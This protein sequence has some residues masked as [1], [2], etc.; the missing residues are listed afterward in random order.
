MRFRRF[1]ITAN[2]NFTRTCNGPE[3]EIPLFKAAWRKETAGTEP[4]PL[5]DVYEVNDG[6]DPA[7]SEYARLRGTYGDDLVRAVYPTPDNLGMAMSQA[8]DRT[9]RWEDEEKARAKAALAKAEAEAKAKA[10]GK[11]KAE[12][13]E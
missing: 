8:A 4:L 13:K 2:A 11:G 1:H 5:P 7:L 12:P 9:A 6:G 10:A 3:Y